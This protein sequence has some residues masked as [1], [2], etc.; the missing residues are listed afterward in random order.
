MQQRQ[1]IGKS[2]YFSDCLPNRIGKCRIEL[3]IAHG[4]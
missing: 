3:R 2:G 4:K 1:Y